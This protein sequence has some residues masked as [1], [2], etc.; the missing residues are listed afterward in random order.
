MEDWALFRVGAVG[1]N[2]PVQQHLLCLADIQIDQI[3]AQARRLHFE[4]REKQN[5]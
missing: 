3:A 4:R 2:P 5:N 1:E